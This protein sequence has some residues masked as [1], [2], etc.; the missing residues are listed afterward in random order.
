MWRGISLANKCL[1][2]FGAAVVLIIVA[3][4]SVPWLRMNGIIEES[5]RRLA[6][7]LVQVWEEQVQNRAAAGAAVIPGEP[8]QLADADI[9]LLRKEQVV[10][11]ADEDR[12]VARAWQRFQS[13]PDAVERYDSTWSRAGREDRYAKVQRGEDGEPLGIIL[14]TRRAPA[15]ILDL[16]ADTVFYFLSAGLI[17]LGLAVLVFYLIITRL[18]L[19]PVRELR[20]TAELVRRGDINVRS[21]IST[22]D[23]FEE[24]S[25]TFNQM[26]E[27]LAAS[28][29]QLRAINKSLDVKLSELSERNIA[30]HEANRL[31]GEFVA[32]VSHELRT[33]LNSII[34]FAE[35][36]LEIAEREYAAGD[37]STRLAKRRRY[38]E[39]ITTAGRSLLEM[40]NGL[41][42]IAKV[43][44]GRVDLRPEQVNVAELCEGLC[45]MMRP[46]A[47]KSGVELSMEP[48]GDVPHIHT[49]PK[50]LQQIVYNLLSNAI[51]FTGDA[52]GDS[53]GR[54]ARVTLRVERL[55]GRAGEGPE[56]EDRVRISV[57]DTGPGIAAEDLPII[58][59]KFRQLES[60]HTRRHAGTG[61]GLAISKELAQILQGEINVES[62][63][64]RGSMFSLILPLKL[65]PIRAEE[66]RLELAFRGTLAGR[67]APPPAA[68]EP[69]APDA[70]GNGHAP[71]PAPD[72]DPNVTTAT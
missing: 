16:L 41:L 34:G 11:L 70:P 71:A 45:A 30:L 4:L 21:N 3:A 72:A 24:L 32:N 68:A 6:R 29:E 50:K 2:L 49:D 65:N 57:I 54:P 69:P 15:A 38:L 12:F 13:D 48:V 62:E 47:D 8:E 37:D 27:A 61:L 39:H 23:E 35:L 5:N 52:A 46:V 10:A 26:L 51:K 40:I 36:L 18:I 60:D 42:E 22:G 25:D 7:Q 19:S 63:P 17:A 28:Q 56:A 67:A 33:P 53:P 43:E 58:F 55:V 59:E 1:L 44:A 9:V 66:T 64:G 31:K 14:L 20:E